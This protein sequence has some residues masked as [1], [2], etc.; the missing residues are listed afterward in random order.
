METK[1]T[2]TQQDK[3]VAAILYLKGEL[4]AHTAPILEKAI[5]ELTEKERYKIL[6]NFRDLSYISSAGLGV[7]MEFIETVRGKGG[8]IK[9]SDMNEKVFSIFDLLGFPA[10]FDIST[11]EETAL[12]KFDEASENM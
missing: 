12:Q 8:D 1:F 7:F 9:L 11:D 6:I 4:D 2:I 5:S 10:F 3:E